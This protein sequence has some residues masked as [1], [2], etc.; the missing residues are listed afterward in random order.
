MALD[1]ECAARGLA[2]AF[3]RRRELAGGP[4][5][6]RHAR[7]A[8]RDR[9]DELE[10]GTS[11]CGDISRSD[12][13]PEGALAL[14][15]HHDEDVEVYLNGAPIALRSRAIAA[16]TV[17]CASTRARA[18]TCS[19][20]TTC[21]RSTAIRRT[22]AS[23][24]T[25]DWSRSSRMG[26]ENRAADRSLE[27]S[28]ADMLA[29]RGDHSHSS[30]MPFPSSVD[31]NS[32]RDVER[33]LGAVLVAV[34]ERARQRVRAHRDRRRGGRLAEQARAAAN[35][36]EPELLG[37]DQDAGKGLMP[38]A[39][40]GISTSP[41]AIGAP[42]AVG[43]ADDPRAAAHREEHHVGTASSAS[44][45]ACRRDRRRDC[46]CCPHGEAHRGR[47]SRNRRNRRPSEPGVAHTLAGIPFRRETRIA[48]G[49][50]PFAT[51]LPRI[52]STA[53]IGEARVEREEHEMPRHAED[54]GAST[55][56]P[57]SMTPKPRSVTPLQLTR[58]LPS[59]SSALRRA[60]AP[61]GKGRP[62]RSMSTNALPSA[63]PQMASLCTLGTFATPR[64]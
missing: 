60:A 56:S 9:A 61:T 58:P 29:D 18:S 59:S 6:F 32:T 24:S 17:S 50:K 40:G 2:R 13:L 4:G 41:S 37:R 46:R 5:R 28:A 15:I 1:D 55:S 54:R 35:R 48:P 7:H 19:R 12:A 44:R 39:T 57:G 63:S 14:W 26:A 62:G 8:G 52:R 10:H 34:V 42:P 43:T 11:G 53:R 25:W 23:T 36:G 38:P 21:S 22:A 51:A 27:R 30:G 49:A 31:G 3:V 16:A 20:A 33:V 47:R 45:E 64:G